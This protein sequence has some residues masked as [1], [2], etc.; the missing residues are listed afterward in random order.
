[1]D[2]NGP[3]M[4]QKLW[5]L[6]ISQKAKDFLW[7]G[8]LRCLPIK[9]RLLSSHISVEATC[10]LCHETQ[11]SDV[12]VLWDCSYAKACWHSVALAWEIFS[13]TEITEIVFA[14]FQQSS[15]QQCETFVMICWAI[16]KQR[17]E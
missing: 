17:N 15:L 9:V 14:V 13:P 3:S 8:M 7:R 2:P 5:R 16:W 10:C 6:K 12:H 11:E 1:M 4:W